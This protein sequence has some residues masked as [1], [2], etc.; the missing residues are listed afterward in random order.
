MDISENGMRLFFL[1]SLVSKLN[2]DFIQ[3]VFSGLGIRSFLFFIKECGILCVLFCS[4]PFFIKECGIF[5][6][7]FHS[8]LKS[9]MFFEFF[10]V[11]YKRL[12]RSYRSYR[13][14]RSFTSFIKES[15]R[16]LRSFWLHKS[17]KHCKSHKKRT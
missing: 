5:C 9:G 7:L 10:S 1:K 17:H 12:E 3:F 14:Y 8:L 11:L 2:E 16:T 13:S 4:F 15:K 6:V